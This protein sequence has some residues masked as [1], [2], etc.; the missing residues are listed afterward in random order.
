MSLTRI[1]DIAGSGMSAQTVRLNTTASNL[2][3]ADSVS[4]SEGT[5]YKARQPIFSATMADYRRQVYPQ[6]PESVG[7]QIRGILESNVPLKME[8]QPNHPQANAEGMIFKSNV[9]TMEEMANMISA[10]R[11]YQVNVEVSETAKQL[12][13]R[14]LNMGQ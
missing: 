1:F 8:Y 10:S 4:S 11:T 12:W 13:M 7:V 14:T 5:T 3:N 6:T 2:A 9:N